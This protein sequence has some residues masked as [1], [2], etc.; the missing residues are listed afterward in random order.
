[1]AGAASV[2]VRTRAGWQ[3]WRT[4]SGCPGGRDGAAAQPRTL[5]PAAG[6]LD[7][8]V[9]GDGVS[10]VEINTMD[11]PKRTVA[12][13][14][15]RLPMAVPRQM[16]PQ[17]L[18]RAA[19]GAD[20]SYRF[21]PDGTP[22]LTLAFFKVQ[23]LTVHHSG[24]DAPVADPIAHVRGIYYAQA[25]TQDFG[26]IGYQLLIDAD[27]R[28]YEGAYSDPDTVPVFGPAPGADRLPLAVN[29]AHV[30]GFNAGNVGICMLGNFMKAPPTAAALRSLKVILARL[31]ATTE[32]DPLATTEYV[33][34]ISGKKATIAT[35]T[36][37]QDWHRAN[38]DAG[39]TL[40]PGDQLYPLMPAIRKD[41][42]D[43][44]KR[45]PP[46]TVPTGR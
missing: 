36:T 7:Y 16:C 39:A 33:N 40:C 1:M 30:G 6:V 37:H 32:L 44:A 26:D 23:T 29:G 5:I 9:R 15:T 28:V 43:L 38:P 11:G 12:A 31:A 10:V 2:R 13:P 4:P 19:W 21:N 22:K 34:P 17:Y 20:E 46:I 8:E 35:I 27:G 24:E 3:P 14:Q 25:V 42:A 18:S 41:V 45:L